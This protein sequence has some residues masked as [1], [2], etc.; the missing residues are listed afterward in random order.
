VKDAVGPGAV[1]AGWPWGAGSSRAETVT[2]PTGWRTQGNV[3]FNSARNRG[4]CGRA[5]AGA[6]TAELNI[7]FP[8]VRKPA[9]SFMTDP[10]RS[11][12]IL[13]ARVLIPVQTH[14]IK[15]PEDLAVGH[16]VRRPLYAMGLADPLFLA[17]V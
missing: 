14:G 4:S 13:C 1:S 5:G 11:E 17:R 2:G 9:A 3:I 7:T 8:C 10:E 12:F 6:V 16:Q 15:W